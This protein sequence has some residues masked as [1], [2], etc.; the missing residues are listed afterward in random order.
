MRWDVPGKP[1]ARE[2]KLMQRLRRRQS[3]Y[4]FLREI[5][6]E[7]FDEAFEAELERAY[8]RPGG[9]K[10]LPP[11]MLAMVTLLQAYDQLS[12]ADAVVEAEF[13]ARWQLV[14]G[15]LGAKQAPF[16]QGVLSQFRERMVAHDLDRKLLE[17]TVRLAK[18]TGKFGWQ[19][20]KYILDSSPLLGAGR[21]EDT[22][23]L[24]G[25][26]LST[27]VDCA[28]KCLG[29]PRQR[30]LDDAR[31]TLLS[32]PSLKTAL[33][34]DWDDEGQKR[35]ALQRLLGEV[36]SL[37]A[38]VAQ[39]ASEEARKPPLQT[40]LAALQ[41]VLA[42]D[43]EPDPGGG[44]LV[45]RRG[46]AKDRMPSLGDKEMRHGRKSKSKRFNGFKRHIVTAGSL[47]LGAIVLPA[48]QPEHE[49]AGPLLDEAEQH[50]AADGVLIDRGYL[51]SPRVMQLRCEGKQVLCKPWPSRNHGLFTKE[52]FG[53]NLN[54]GELTCPAG[55]K[56]NIS[57]ALLA[58]FDAAN[59][60]TC[61]L[62]ASC[63]PAKL[64][65]GRSVTIHPQEEFLIE[66]RKLRQT[67]EGRAQLRERVQVEHKLAR[68]GSIQGDRSRYK[69]ARKNTLD[70][71]RCAAVAN[72]QDIARITVEER[73]AA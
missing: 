27:V 58:R 37:Q 32:G 7:L 20:V 12:D 48:N 56:A 22:W 73:R 9:D 24:I 45:I 23:N 55:A 44:G 57:E 46:V 68:L 28:A 50:G 19:R 17:R 8:E 54:A 29:V 14:L 13:D 30:V 26:A 69:G 53:I 21:V 25:R 36:E 51:A 47:I 72:L 2:Q 70:A 6:A 4:V 31:L 49:A 11:A 60:A 67:S 39:H 1:S 15:C 16:S 33:D 62:R 40:A 41:R 35:S 63:T 3:F 5:R 18:E 10:S 66:L 59:C 64:G 52:D 42:Q 71:R 43:L 61:G 38:W 65:R 34:I